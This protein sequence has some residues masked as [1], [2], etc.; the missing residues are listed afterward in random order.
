MKICQ[1]I[2][3]VGICTFIMLALFSFN[4]VSFAQVTNQ[5][6]ANSFALYFCPD[7]FS[8][9]DKLIQDKYECP[10]D[11]DDLWAIWTTGFDRRFK[12]PDGRRLKVI[13]NWNGMYYIKGLGSKTVKGSWIKLLLEYKLKQDCPN[14]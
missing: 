3:P 10:G 9:V 13:M 4:G 8:A 5:A 14:P 7:A 6:L 11:D 12:C 2:F 1:K